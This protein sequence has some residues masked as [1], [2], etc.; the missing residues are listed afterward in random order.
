MSGERRKG[1]E[2]LKGMIVEKLKIKGQEKRNE[3]TD[4]KECSVGVMKISNNKM[5]RNEQ[6][7]VTNDESSTMR[8]DRFEREEEVGEL[9]AV[10]LSAKVHNDDSIMRKKLIQEERVNLTEITKHSIGKEVMD[11]NRECNMSKG[12]LEKRLSQKQRQNEE[13]QKLLES[14]EQRI[15]KLGKRKHEE[16]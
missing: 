5:I 11:E 13:I 4:L 6:R 14:S 9:N 16:S 10:L 2:D 15:M 3:I 12:V 1:I 7:I 8:S